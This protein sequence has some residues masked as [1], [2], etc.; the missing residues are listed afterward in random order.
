M[1]D[2]NETGLTKW[3]R[4]LLIR[5]CITLDL[6]PGVVRSAF[7]PMCCIALPVW[8]LQAHHIYPKSK[9]PE[10]AYSLWNG[11]SLCMNCHMHIVHSGNS[12][13]DVEEL[14]HWRFF[15]PAFR[16]YNSLVLADD[17]NSENQTKLSNYGP[18]L[19]SAHLW[20]VDLDG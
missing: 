2:F 6:F 4:L 20:D 16:R 15:V 7:C 5:D 11:I 1:P 13:K 18:S 17:F 9:Y 8:R 14:H 12:F 3:R 19:S 10:F